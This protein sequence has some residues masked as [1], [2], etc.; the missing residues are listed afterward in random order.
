VWAGDESRSLT[1]DLVALYAIEAPQPAIA[2][3]KLDGLLNRYGFDDGPSTAYFRIHATRDKDHAALAAAAL[4]GYLSAADPFS[5]LGEA[6][7]VHKGYW[8]MLDGLE[9]LRS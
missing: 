1:Q 5:L 8:H 3:T 6:E 2:R 9:G 7:A 4:Q